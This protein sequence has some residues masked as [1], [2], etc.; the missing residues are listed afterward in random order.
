M[1]HSLNKK[2]TQQFSILSLPILSPYFHISNTQNQNMAQTFL[3]ILVIS[4]T[5]FAF[6]TIVESR[7]R[8]RMY[9]ESQC[10]SAMYPDLCV[11]TLLPYVDKSG[12]LSPQRLA[13][14]SLASCLS[15]AL[16][17]KN[18]VD[19]VAKNMNQTGNF[20]EYQALEECV[21]QIDNGVDQIM[22]S[23]N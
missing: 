18:Y 14:I 8:A 6:S 23:F 22:Q 15:K 5:F 17:M 4:L 16:V 3:S 10:R 7:S 2:C 13:Q 20:G 21:Q 12:V 9:L 1:V 19:M 11:R